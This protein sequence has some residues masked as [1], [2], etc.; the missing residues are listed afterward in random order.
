[1]FLYIPDS[2]RVSDYFLLRIWDHGRFTSLQNISLFLFCS[3]TMANFSAFLLSPWS[4]KPLIADLWPTS[5]WPVILLKSTT[6]SVNE[7]LLLSD[8]EHCALMHAC[9]PVASGW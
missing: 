6:S 4:F 7:A 3:L 5:I 1:M 9:G 2:E 8:T